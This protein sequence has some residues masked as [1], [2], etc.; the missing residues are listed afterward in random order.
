MSLIARCRWLLLAMLMGVGCASKETGQVEG[1]QPARA[2][3]SFAERVTSPNM[4]T[5]MNAYDVQF[6]GENFEGGVAVKQSSLS[7]K[8]FYTG[9]N[10]RHEGRVFSTAEQSHFHG[11]FETETMEQPEANLATRNSMQN[12]DAQPFTG[13]YDT[14]DSR[15]AGQNFDTDTL[16][17][18]EARVRGKEQ[19]RI[20]EEYESPPPMTIDDV[21]ELLNKR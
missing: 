2:E 16:L 19:D 13:G 18:R 7:E 17:S 4:S 9:S 6:E 20:D 1:M 14:R 3:Q 15:E 8:A 10:S 21:R 5:I 11:A 12:L